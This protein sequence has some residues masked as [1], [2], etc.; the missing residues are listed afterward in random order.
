[1]GERREKDVDLGEWV[2]EG[3]RMVRNLW[4]EGKK[5]WGGEISNTV[6]NV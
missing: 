1:M 3:K 4:K 5:S 6:E 2:K